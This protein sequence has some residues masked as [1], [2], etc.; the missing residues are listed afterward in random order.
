L[1]LW[2]CPS[3]TFSQIRELLLECACLKDVRLHLCCCKQGVAM[4]AEGRA[5]TAGSINGR[6]RTVRDL[7]LGFCNKVDVQAKSLAREVLE[8]CPALK[9]LALK[10]GNKVDPVSLLVNRAPVLEQLDVF[11]CSLLLTPR[12]K[13]RSGALPYLHSFT[14]EECRQVTSEILVYLVRQC[15][16]LSHLFLGLVPWGLF[17]DFPTF[18]GLTC[19]LGTCP[20]LTR[21][22]MVNCCLQGSLAAEELPLQLKLQAVFH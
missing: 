9:K 13:Y 22:S 11:Q 5:V 14:L 21:L 18:G 2:Q 17:R 6:S 3:L 8:L 20:N 7:T 16:R 1:A 15:P 12:F 10:F 19:L 4:K